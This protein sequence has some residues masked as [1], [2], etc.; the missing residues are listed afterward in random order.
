MYKSSINKKYLENEKIQS[1]VRIAIIS[2]VIANILYLQ[3][4]SDDI[5]LENIAQTIFFYPV[6]V[7]FFSLLY[8]Y[9]LNHY[10]ALYQKQRII[11]MSVLDVT[12]SVIVMYLSGELSVYY[13]VLLLWFVAGYGMR[14]GVE[15]GYIIYMATIVAWTLLLYFSD[16]WSHNLDVGL[17][18]LIAYLVIPLYFFKLVKELRKSIF[19][20]HKEVDDSNYKALHDPLTHLPNRIYFDDT[21]RNYI[22]NSQQKDHKFALIFI[23]LDGFKTINDS[24][25][26]EVGDL[27]L[28]EVSKRISSLDGFT[29][30]LG[31]DEFVALINFKMENELEKQLE[32]LMKNLNKECSNPQIKLSASV[33]IALYPDDATTM[34]DLKK[35][36]DLAMYKAKEKGKNRYMYFSEIVIRNL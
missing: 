3:Y 10:P 14:Y 35:K 18:W 2:L 7:F 29:S 24:F 16:F 9:F 15:I 6:L 17:G 22:Q 30:R 33:G 27:V 31:G 11:I 36:S 8:L 4:F 5:F 20:L 34:Y 23:D 1:Y 21:L 32:K 13:P 25:G 19:Q 28:V 12:A 26:H